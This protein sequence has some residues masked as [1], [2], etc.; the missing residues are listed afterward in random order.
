MKLLQLVPLLV[1]LG[2]LPFKR[3]NLASKLGALVLDT[4]RG[5]GLRIAPLFG[6]LQL[7]L[8]A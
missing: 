5:G 6:H 2:A 4:S 3:M 1:Q 8:G 7:C